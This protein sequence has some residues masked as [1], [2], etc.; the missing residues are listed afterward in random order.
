MRLHLGVMPR[1]I[2]K[3]IPGIGRESTERYSS[4]KRLFIDPLSEM[5]AHLNTNTFSSE[6]LLIKYS[7]SLPES[8]MSLLD[9]VNRSLYQHH[10][11][12]NVH[13][14]HESCPVT[15]DENLGT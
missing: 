5:S 9:I 2:S 11:Y 4:S 13:L 14:R 3:L 7:G 1:N 12:K 15:D 10:L 6:M 8:V